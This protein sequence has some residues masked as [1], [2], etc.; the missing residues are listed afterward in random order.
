MHAVE[1]V[2]PGTGSIAPE[3]NVGYVTRV[4]GEGS[5]RLHLRAGEVV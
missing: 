3:F 4:E 5:L 1:T 2:N